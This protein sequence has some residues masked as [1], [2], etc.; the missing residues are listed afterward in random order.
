MLSS[1]QPVLYIQIAPRHL[2]LRNAK[3]GEALSEVAEIAFQRQPKLKVLGVGN[4]A[5]GHAGGS[6]EIAHPFAHPRSLVSDFTLGEQLLKALIPRLLGRGFLV[7]A[8]V[9]ILHPLG[10]P[11]GGFTQIEIRAL[12]E[13]ALGAGATKVMVW[14]GPSLTDQQILT[15]Q[16]PA[17]GQVLV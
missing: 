10:Q 13:M 6:V 7:P 9:V 16:F 2:S 3:T 17:E 8:P 15:R 12:Q 5:R 11:E 1:L 4:D 14:Q